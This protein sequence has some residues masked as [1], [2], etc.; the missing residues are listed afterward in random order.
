MRLAKPFYKLPIRF[1]VERMRAE[2]AALPNSAWAKHPNDIKGNTSLR[3]ISVGGGENDDV[4]GHMEPTPHLLQCSYIQQVLSGFGVVWSRSRLLRLSAHHGVPQHADIN[5][6]WFYRA[7]LHIPIVTHPDVRFYCD[8]DSVHMLAGEAWIFDNWRLHR[9]E[10]PV[11]TERVHLVADTSGSAAFWQLVGQGELANA[12]VQ[13]H[14]FEPSRPVRLLTERTVLEPVMAPAEVDLLILDLRSELTAPDDSPE[15]TRRLIQFHRLLDSFRREWRQ[16]YALFGDS[17]TAWPEYAKLRD[18]ARTAAPLLGKG[19][20]MR[21][22]RI[23]AHTVLEARVLRV[24]LSGTAI[25][26][27]KTV[28]RIKVF[29]KSVI[30][31]AAPRS[32][33]TL[34]FET[35][36]ANSKVCTLGGEAHWLIESIPE[37]QLG[38]QGVES[39]RLTADQYSDSIGATIVSN[40]LQH[41]VDSS[42]RSVNPDSLLR[43]VEKTPK[44]ALR[45]PFFNRLFPDSRFIH[46]WRDPRENINSIMEAWRS[47]NWKTYN[48]LD[49]F[50]GPWSLLLPPGWRQMNGKSLEEIAAF[51]WDSAN[52]IILD[53]LQTIPHERWTMVGYEELITDTESTIRRLCKF[54]EIEMDDSISLRISK[55]LPLSR[56]TQ[57]PPSPDKWH[58]NAAEIN[59]VI[60]NVESTWKRIRDIA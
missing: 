58:K 13:I 47:G 18:S 28:D 27:K 34:L 56:F 16:L 39:N 43:F 55:A 30:I 19:L 3:L 53:D 52:R 21:T 57:T 59:R 42:G 10:N 40:L 41:R 4:N 44:N 8:K 9:V 46:L 26:A 37:L 49:G 25:A 2:V 12:Q 11:N 6:H 5:Y 14:R 17:S 60:P 23:A 20:F 36:A 54:A 29:D 45:I 24:V 22:N 7:R 51:Q 32:G 35:L 15:E 50:E 33:S 38:A 1:D 31:V 48:G